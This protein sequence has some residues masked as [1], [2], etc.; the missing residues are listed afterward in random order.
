M[1]RYFFHV[2]SGSVIED[3]VG[4]VLGDDAEAQR[5]AHRAGQIAKVLLR[6]ERFWIVV[7]DEQKQPV[8]ELEI[9]GAEHSSRAAK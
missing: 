2:R 7:T 6:D 1:P 3:G 4:V 5:E 8:F 9:Q